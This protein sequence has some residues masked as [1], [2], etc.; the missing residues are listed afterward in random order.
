M[1][2]VAVADSAVAAPPGIHVPHYGS[3][4]VTVVRFRSTVLH[5]HVTCLV[6]FLATALA[7]YL[8][9]LDEQSVSCWLAAN[10]SHGFC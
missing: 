1:R 4:T 5:V 3:F 8:P 2:L 7:T 9:A 6:L 10:P